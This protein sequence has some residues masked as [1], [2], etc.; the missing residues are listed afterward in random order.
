VQRRLTFSDWES[1]S[2]VVRSSKIDLSV[3][4]KA[5]NA[6]RAITCASGQAT[7]ISFAGGQNGE[8]MKSLLAE[9]GLD[10]VWVDTATE[11]RFC[12]TLVD[13]DG[14]RIRELVEDAGPVTL[15]EWGELFAKVEQA[16][17]FH[18]GLLLCGS[19]PAEAPKEVY[20]TLTRLAHDA[21]KPVAIDAKGAELLA[22]LSE[23]PEL[24]KINQ[25]ELQAA[26]READ[27]RTGMNHLHRL[28]VKHVMI[29]AGPDPVHILSGKKFRILSLPKIDPVNPIGGGDTVTGV[30]FLHLIASGNLESAALQGLGAGTAQTLTRD[31]AQ[32]DPEQAL[33][34]AKRITV[35]KA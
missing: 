33:D 9:E 15:H 18:S 1:D 21:G 3:G 34:F 22:A 13:A 28:G 32:F 5:T 14:R 12:Q 16:L 6:A 30:T 20:A 23:T 29:T 35:Q 4:G 7:V 2:D 31:P 11:S 17:P 25:S 10:G 27:V 24:V 19:L 8:R 26:T